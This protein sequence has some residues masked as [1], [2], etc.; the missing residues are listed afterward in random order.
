MKH[1]PKSKLL[2]FTAVA[3]IFIQLNAQTVLICFPR[4]KLN[5]QEELT[6]KF[7]YLDL[8]AAID[9]NDNHKVILNADKLLKLDDRYV[10]VYSDRASAYMNLKQY[11]EA[12][13][14][15]NRIIEINNDKNISDDFITYC[16]RGL[17]FFYKNDFEKAVS[18]IKTGIRVQRRKTPHTYCALAYVYTAKGFY[19]KAIES[20]RQ[21][22]DLG[23]FYP[24]ANIALCELY[25]ISGDYASA[26]TEC[27]RISTFILPPDLK[28]YSLMLVA[29][30]K[31]LSD[32]NAEREI[33]I[34]NNALPEKPSTHI[35]F[36][37]QKARLSHIISAPDKKD[38]I[39]ALFSKFESAYPA[40]H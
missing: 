25:I 19:D 5:Q 35:S 9:S 33:E 4:K 23:E 3:L 34:F 15:Y 26:K 40:P 38:K 8:K 11:D 30:N 14:D 24:K 10:P 36:S 13:N 20:Y 16:N 29:I 12:I 17:C 39:K 6:W 22:I 31:I 28:T 1:I 27:D 21:A 32:G 7:S 2:F 37:F 18:D